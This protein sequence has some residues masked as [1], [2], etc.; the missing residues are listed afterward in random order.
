[1]Y[2]KN[3]DCSGHFYHRYIPYL[4]KKPEKFEKSL[5]FELVICKLW[6]LYVNYPLCV[7]LY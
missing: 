1:M 3:K 7:I 4:T 5:T 6:L 2:F